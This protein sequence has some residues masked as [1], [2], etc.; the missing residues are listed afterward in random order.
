MAWSKSR[1]ATALSGHLG[2]PVQFRADASY[3][4][5]LAEIA[6]LVGLLVTR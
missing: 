5:Q 3:D 4:D 1:A 2:V 6:R